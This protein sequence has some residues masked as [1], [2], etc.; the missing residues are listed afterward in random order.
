[1]GDSA[2]VKPVA[3]KT[4][5]IDF[6]LKGYAECDIIRAN[7]ERE[8]IDPHPN[9]ITGNGFGWIADQLYESTRP[10]GPAIYLGLYKHSTAVSSGANPS[11]TDIGDGGLE[12]GEADSEDYA[13]GSKTMEVKKKFTNSSGATVT[14]IRTLTLYNASENGIL[15][16]VVVLDSGFNLDDGD[17]VEVTWKIVLSEPTS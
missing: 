16:H 8:H 17:A 5:G 3:K 2:M 12:R 13:E 1:M 11:I 7:G 9:A 10:I 15:I 6:N 14:A 4:G